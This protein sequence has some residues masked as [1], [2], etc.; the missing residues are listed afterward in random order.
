MDSV[1]LKQ[2]HEEAKQFILNSAA[3]YDRMCSHDYTMIEIQKL[4]DDYWVNREE[5][6]ICLR[7]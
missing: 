7:I 2:M 4:F 5:F 3:L 6:I 1:L